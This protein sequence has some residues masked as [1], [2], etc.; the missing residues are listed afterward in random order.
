[1]DPATCVLQDFSSDETSILWEV[2]RTA[3]A[4]VLDW[5][6]GKPDLRRLGMTW[7]VAPSSTSL[8]K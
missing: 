8:D 1:M 3:R 2:L 6:T 7:R 5:L 4:L